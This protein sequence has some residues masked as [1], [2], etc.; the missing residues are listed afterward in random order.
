MSA[1]AKL[2]TRSNL[3]EAMASAAHGKT[4]AALSVHGLAWQRL[5][6]VVAIVS[7]AA[8]LVAQQV[9]FRLLSPVIGSSVETWSAIIGLFLLGIALGNHLAGKFADRLPAVTLISGSLFG[10]ALA[11]WLM[12]PIANS[13]SGAAIFSALPLTAQ[14]FTASFLV[15]LLPGVTLSF[16]TPPSIRSLVSHV[17]DVGSAAGRIFAWGTFG[18]LMGNYVAG[19]ILLA[20]FGVSSIV[21]MTSVCLLLTSVITFLVGRSKASSQALPGTTV[22]S[23]LTAEPHFDAAARSDSVRWIRRAFLIVFACSF[24]SGALE[25]AAFRILAPLVG[26]SMFLTAGVV[27]VILAGMSFGNYLGGVLATRCS[28]R[29]V[30]RTSLLVC[31]VTTLAVAPVWKVVVSAG[32]LKEIS[33]IPQILF[34]SFTLF[35]LPAIA[36]GTITPQVIRLSVGDVRRAGSISGQLYAWSTIGCIAGILTASWLM[37]ESFGAIRTSLLCGVI[38][39]LLMF[40]VKPAGDNVRSSD[41]LMM[42]MAMLVAAAALLVVCKSPYDYESRYFSLAVS[43]DVIDNRNVKMLV[44]DRLVHSAIDLNDPSFLHYPHEKI[45][46]DFTRTAARDARAAGRQPRILIIGGGGYSFPRWVE[47]QSDLADV[48]LD[49]VEIDPAVTEIAHDKLGLSRSTRI[50]SIHMDGRQFVKSAPAASYDLVI[51]D[52][53]NDLSVPYH[54]MTAEYNVLIQRLLQSEGVYLLTVIDSMEYGRFLTSAVRTVQ[55]SFEETQLLAPVETS[56]LSERSVFVIAGRS[57]AVR[58]ADWWADRSSAHAFSKADVDQLVSRNV[59]MS[60]LLTD[61]YAP[62]DT[63]MISHFLN[64]AE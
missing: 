22:A 36:F 42:P 18:S 3:I 15:C 7:N 62:V 57:G 49:V 59:Q 11:V 60:P 27:G 47:S 29:S 50:N 46:G 48:H 53:V 33:M 30:L 38:P 14:I 16:V 54:L 10:S 61:D 37:I 56:S 51:Q 12:I 23:T 5:I 35:L 19:F 9:A 58:R 63:L 13:L 26:V 45:Q 1:V 6:V 64:R 55:H 44:L 41:R 8:L 24:A 39:V 28:S 21:Q 52:A 31:A 4:G 17:D 43:D 32:V 25:G 40:F 34:W 2:E 20:M